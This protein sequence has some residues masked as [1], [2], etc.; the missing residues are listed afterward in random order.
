MSD[1]GEFP[2]KNLAGRGLSVPEKINWEKYRSYVVFF[3]VLHLFFG[4]IRL[5]LTAVP[6]MERKCKKKK[7]LVRN[8]VSSQLVKYEI[9]SIIP[10][11]GHKYS[12]Y[13]CT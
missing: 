6:E 9:Q 10:A 7:R 2:G 11:H 8:R 5:Y 12:V 4:T 1:L 13:L 3:S